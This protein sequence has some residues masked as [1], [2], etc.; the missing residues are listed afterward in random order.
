MSAWSL[1][2]RL[3]TSRYM[4]LLDTAP[5]CTSDDQWCLWVDK[6]TGNAWLAQAANWLIAK[7]LALL[8]LVLLALGVRWFL[9]RVIDRLVRRAAEGLP[10]PVLRR[11]RERAQH[12]QTVLAGRR[13]QR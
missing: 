6:V 10:S 11:R 4:S 5:T 7:P 2:S 3:V 1:R 9:H 12:G 8:I 13:V